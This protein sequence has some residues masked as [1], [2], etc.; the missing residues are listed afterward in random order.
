MRLELFDNNTFR[1]LV[2]DGSRRLKSG[3]KGRLWLLLGYLRTK[4]GH[5]LPPTGTLDPSVRKSLLT[6]NILAL[7]RL[8]EQR[9]LLMQTPSLA[10]SIKK[11]SAFQPGQPL[12]GVLN[13]GQT[14]VGVFPEGEEP[15]IY[16]APFYAVAP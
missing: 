2:V 15:I 8:F 9:A 4:H 5:T 10:L 1:Y 3:K 14:E 6:A 12:P 16:S 7:E 11:S 13:F